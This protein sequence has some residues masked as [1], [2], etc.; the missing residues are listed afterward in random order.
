MRN[1]LPE[2]REVTNAALPVDQAGHRVALTFCRFNDQG[3]IMVG[4]IV[5]PKRNTMAGQ[6]VPDRDAEG[7]PRKLDQGEHGVYMTEATWEP[8]VP[9]AC[10][11][12]G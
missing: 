8:Q 4:D 3:S 9:T 12:S 6:D 7:R 5:K 1:L 10:F 11:S 2:I